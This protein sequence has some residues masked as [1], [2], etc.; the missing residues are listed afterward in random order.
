MCNFNTFNA[1]IFVIVTL[2]YLYIKGTITHHVYQGIEL[3]LLTNVD[4]SVIDIYI[5]IVIYIDIYIYILNIPSCKSKNAKFKI[6]EL[7]C[8]RYSKM[9][10]VS[11]TL[12]YILHICSHYIGCKVFYAKEL[13]P[14]PRTK[15]GYQFSNCI[16][17]RFM[18]GVLHIVIHIQFDC[19]V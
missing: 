13:R 4:L 5:D 6:F 9:S 16:G 7:N 12:P 17:N 8:F 19:K 11:N 15:H 3:M 2:H 14:P 10:N 18:L 1:H